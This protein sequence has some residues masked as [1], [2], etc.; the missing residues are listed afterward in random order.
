MGFLGA[1]NILAKKLCNRKTAKSKFWLNLDFRFDKVTGFMTE[2]G[3]MKEFFL[4][5]IKGLLLSIWLGAAI[6]FSL[7]ISE[8]AF[9]VLPS[10][11]TAGDLVNKTLSVINYSGLVVGLILLMTSFLSKTTSLSIWIER[12][13]FLVLGLCCALGQFVL[14]TWM[15]GLRQ[16]IDRPL[17][18]LSSD[19]SVRKAFTQLHDYSVALLVVAMIAAFIAYF[20]VMGKLQKRL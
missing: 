19:D 12:G 10:S 16:Q 14:V 9:A 11:L 7:V 6:F 8:T 5:S 18:E 1:I 15:H 17:E 4:S 13:L 20:L 3:F 2:S